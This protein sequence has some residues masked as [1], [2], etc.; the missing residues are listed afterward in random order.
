MVPLSLIL[1]ID[2]VEE[3]KEVPASVTELYDRYNDSVLGREDKSKGIEVLFEYLI[4]KRFLSSLAF[5]EFIQKG[6][7]EITKMAFNDFVNQYAKEYRM[8][9]EELQ[10]FISE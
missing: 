8:D 10:R 6:A 9:E 3:H 5:N 7:V 2:I 1:L 4:K